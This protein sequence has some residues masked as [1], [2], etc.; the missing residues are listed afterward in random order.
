M[1]PNAI[2]WT[3]L[4][5]NGAVIA[6]LLYGITKGIPNMI[7]AFRDEQSAL[8]DDHREDMTAAHDRSARLASSGHD[9][10]KQLSESVDQVS[11]NVVQ[12][13][14]HIAQIPCRNHSNT[15]G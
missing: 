3:D 4:T 5:S 10:V 12:L 8:R 7:Q 6:A 15:D 13:R 14:E 9:A 1:E 11:Q 2:N